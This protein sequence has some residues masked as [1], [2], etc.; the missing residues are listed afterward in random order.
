MCFQ[1]PDPD[2][3]NTQ[4]T[5]INS[6]SSICRLK[7]T[8][9]IE[10]VRFK[11]APYVETVKIQCSVHFY[12]RPCINA[13]K[14]NKKSSNFPQNYL[15]LQILVSDNNLRIGKDSGFA[16]FWPRDKYLIFPGIDNVKIDHALTFG[17]PKKVFS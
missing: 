13:G 8:R 10:W 2:Y 12:R 5:P 15:K 6:N 4:T 7:K 14:S 11:A 3:S 16:K 9:N 1:M 17:M